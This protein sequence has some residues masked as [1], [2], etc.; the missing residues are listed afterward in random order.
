MALRKRTDLLVLHTSATR[1]SMDIGAAEIRSWHL[2]KGWSDIGYHWVIR[3]N[4]QIEAGRQERA[5]GAHVAGSNS[6]SI[7]VCLV[8]GLNER[9]GRAEDNY[10]GAQWSSLKVLAG[11]IVRRYPGI[12]ILGHRDLSPD[13]DGDGLVERSEWLKQCPCFHARDWARANG[14]AAAAGRAEGEGGKSRLPV[15]PGPDVEQAQIDLQRHGFDPGP[16]DGLA[17]PKTRRAIEAFQRS[18]RL[19]VTGRLDAGSAAALA[20]ENF[21]LKKRSDETALQKPPA[22][23]PKAKPADEANPSRS[24]SP[25]PPPEPQADPPGLHSHLLSLLAAIRAAFFMERKN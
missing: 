13:R 6:R 8:G 21:W 18:N 4:G 5:I 17:G 15:A 16:I 3:R 2:G 24:G 22:A 14:F 25:R 1:A 12:A 11:N 19:S 9:T 7:G 20:G 10:T 23:V